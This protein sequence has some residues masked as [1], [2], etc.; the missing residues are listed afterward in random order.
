MKNIS[1]FILFYFLFL[2]NLVYANNI[3]EREW[4]LS[5]KATYNTSIIKKFIIDGNIWLSG[6][7]KNQNKI[8]YSFNSGGNNNVFAKELVIPNIKN[9]YNILELEVNVTAENAKSN[10]KPIGLGFEILITYK[11]KTKKLLPVKI[12][13]GSYS[14]IFKK[15]FEIKNHI[16]SIKIW[17]Y[18]RGESSSGKVGVGPHVVL[19]T[20]GAGETW[21]VRC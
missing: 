18:H 3:L 12:K 19:G 17:G 1:N 8:L 6:F 11:D 13:Q 14:E 15:Q 9:K 10:F 20:R 4:L 16:S 2:P 7:E 21:G 5:D